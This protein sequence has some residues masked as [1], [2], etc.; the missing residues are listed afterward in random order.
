MQREIRTDIDILHLDVDDRYITAIHPKMTLP[1]MRFMRLVIAQCKQYDKSFYEYDFRVPELAKLI[2][3]S[4][5]DLYKT[6]DALSTKMMQTFLQESKK[7]G[8]RKQ[9]SKWQIFQTCKYKNGVL[10][11]QL[12]NDAKELFL[13]LRKYT[14]MPLERV[15]SLHYPHAMRIYELISM[16]MKPIQPHSNVFRTVTITLEELKKVTGTN[17]K[18]Y[19][20]R[21]DNIKTR[22]LMPALEDIEANAGYHIEVEDI[23]QGRKIAGFTLTVWSKYGYEYVKM[24][25][26]E[27]KPIPI[28]NRPE[29]DI[30]PGTEE[31]GP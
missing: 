13:Q 5:D 31:I 16:K 3:C 4:Q 23:K 30:W 9:F 25:E 1:E 17:S 11:V 24:C 12:S 20:G 6:V 7:D 14:S 22:V 10:K 15:L 28:I 27:G 2:D 18:G 26:A 19:E 21:V 29:E 8:R